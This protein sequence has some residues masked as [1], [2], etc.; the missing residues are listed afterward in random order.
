MTT[1][2]LETALRAVIAVLPREPGV[3]RFRDDRGRPLYIGRATRLRDRVRSYWGDLGDRRHLRR[4]VPQIRRIEALV[5]ASEHEAGWLERN[6]LQESKPRWNRIRGGM[7]HPAYLDLDLHPTRPRLRLV[8]SPLEASGEL[9]GP[10]LGSV[11][12]RQ[13]LAALQT[14]FPLAYAMEQA[15]GAERDLARILGVSAKDREGMINN[16]RA[17]LVGEPAALDKVEQLVRL[18]QQAAA[19][20]EAYERAGELERAIKA[21][22]W[23]VQPQQVTTRSA[24]SLTVHGWAGGWLLGLQ[25]R[26]GQLVRW[27]E[28]RTT[29]ALG[30]Q[31]AAAT[32]AVWRAFVDGNTELSAALRAATAVAAIDTPTS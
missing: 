31:R 15:T 10:Y 1:A 5:C 29:R 3:Y 16:T 30:E 8:R 26:D 23:L 28:R 17:A 25:I 4:M 7:E 24:E 9:Y 18:R 2:S 12:T 6:L 27:G 11:R 32:P 20:A 13:A 19:A 14:A 21:L 22:R